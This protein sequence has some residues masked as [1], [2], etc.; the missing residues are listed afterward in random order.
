MPLIVHSTCRA[1]A[2]IAA[3]LLATARPRSSWQCVLK[4]AFEALGTAAMMAVKNSAISSGV[5]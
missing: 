2:L 3:K 1:P 5:Q 4:M